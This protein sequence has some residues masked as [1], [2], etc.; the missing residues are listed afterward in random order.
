M[1]I[2]LKLLFGLTDI[3][4][5]RINSHSFLSYPMFNSRKN[6]EFKAKLECKEKVILNKTNNKTSVHTHPTSKYVKKT[7]KINQFYLFLF[8]STVT[9]LKRYVY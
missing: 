1:F 3:T 9:N 6:C 4:L 5:I 8:I 2:L 7:E